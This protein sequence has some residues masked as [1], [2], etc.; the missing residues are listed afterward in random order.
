MRLT[1]P[2][3]N[4]EEVEMLA[5]NGAGEFFCGY[6][7]Q[8]GSI[9]TVAPSGSIEEGRWWGTSFNGTTSPSWRSDPTPSA[10]PST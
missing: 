4:L 6:V 8:S 10:S 3:S 1:V 9:G 2:V 5:E 7:P